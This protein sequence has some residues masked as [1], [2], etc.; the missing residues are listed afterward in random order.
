MSLPAMSLEMMNAERKCPPVYVAWARP[1]AT[2]EITP[3][4]PL[5]SEAYGLL[6]TSSLVE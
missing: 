3:L 4:A 1:V 2:G 5:Y 6:F